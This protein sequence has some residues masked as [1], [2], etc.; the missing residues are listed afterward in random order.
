INA[1]DRQPVRPALVRDE[2][3][4]EH[5]L[6][7][8][9]DLLHGLRELHAAGLAAT[10]RMHLGLD[11]PELAAERFGR[12]ARLFFTRRNAAF[13]YRD[14]VLGEQR[15]RLVFVKIHELCRLPMVARARPKVGGRREGS[16]LSM[17]GLDSV[18]AARRGSSRPK[19]SSRGPSA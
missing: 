1:V 9:G 18:K 14:A 8:L 11:D 4:A 5:R 15:L 19:A 7:V 6:R 13:R 16:V 12:L 3:L 2:A 10:A 17:K